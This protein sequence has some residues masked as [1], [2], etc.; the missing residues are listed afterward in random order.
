MEA[1]ERIIIDTC[2]FDFSGSKNIG[3]EYNRIMQRAPEDSH[4]ILRDGDSC[5]LTHDYGIHIAEYVRLFP[6][7][8]L[9]CWTNRIH[10]KA[11]QQSKVEVIPYPGDGLSYQ[12]F[13]TEGS[14]IVDARD[15]SDMKH[16]LILAENYKKDLYQVTPLHGFISGFCMI[17]PKKVWELHKFSEVQVYEGRGPHNLLG[18]D[19]DFTNRIR[20]A[21]VQVLRCDGIYLFHIYRMLQGDQDKSH[22]L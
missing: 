20:A 8:V 5:W 10:E 18:C 4:V 7:A 6:D 22:L 16:H 9:T 14:E 15:S 11:E 13:S 2:V 3:A 12:P 21:G 1:S 17:L 19:N